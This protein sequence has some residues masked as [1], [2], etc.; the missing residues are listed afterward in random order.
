MTFLTGAGIL[1]DAMSM[2]QDTG[3]TVRAKLL[4]FVNV[5]AQKLAVVRPWLWLNTSATLTPVNNVIVK[6]ADFGEFRF[7]RFGNVRAFDNRNRL[8]EG[9]AW[10]ADN[11]V[12]AAYPIGFTEDNDNIYLHGAGWADSLIL[13]Y[14]IEPPAIADSADATSWPVKCRPTFIKAVLDHYY[15]YDMDERKAVNVQLGVA[16]LAELKKWDNGQKPRTQN[17]RHGYHR[18][19]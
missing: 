5:T 10:K 6:P 19:R 4:R 14:T 7:I 13:G 16:E 18:S 11:V 3:T 8:D 12:G 9:E 1:D 15:E 17:N 2:I